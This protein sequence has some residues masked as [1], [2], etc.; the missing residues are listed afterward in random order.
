[1]KPDTTAVCIPDYAA[2]G[3]YTMSAN[4]QY[5]MT[6]KQATAVHGGLT[7]TTKMPCA[8]YS[9]PTL[10]CHTGFRMAKI[11]GSICSTCYADKGNY[12]KYQNNILPSQMARLESISDPLWVDAMVTSIG[13]DKYFRWHDS[14]DI[15]D[16]DHLEKIAEVCKR[17]PNCKHWLPT[18]ESGIVNA[19]IAQYDIPE[20]LV[21]RVSAMFVDKPVKIPAS[22]HGVPGIAAS[23]VHHKAPVNGQAC[24]APTQN[25]E[26]RDCRAC[27]DRS[28][29]AISY[30]QH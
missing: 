29:P 3:E 2:D 22:M 13:A 16:I 27:W 19:F 12:H 24:I 25:G 11:A 15:Q 17:T 14:G 30:H 6:K 5:T 10:A 18:R 1:M 9:L 26:C 4:G 21:I 23:N 7:Y 8:S 20:N 28:V